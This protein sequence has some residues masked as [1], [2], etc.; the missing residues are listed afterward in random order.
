MLLKKILTEQTGRAKLWAASI[1]AALGISLLLFS[2]QIYFDF[3]KIL[4]GGHSTHDKNFVSVNKPVSLVNALVQSGFRAEEIEELRKQP[5]IESVATFTNAQ[6]KVSASSEMLHFYTEMFL[7]S[8]ENEFLD[9]EISKFNWV[10]GAQIVPIVL[11]RDYLALYNFGFAAS[12]GLPQ[13]SE[14]TIGN[15]PFDL[16]IRSDDGRSQAFRGRVMGFSERINSILVPKNF[17]DWANQHFGKAVQKSKT[18]RLLLA[19]RQGQDET[20][21]N[22]AK[23]NELE[24]S[25]SKL[26]AFAPLVYSLLTAISL[27]AVVLIVLSIFIFLLNYQLIIEKSS[28]NIRL[29]LQT[30]YAPQQ[31]IGVLQKSMFQWLFLTFSM[32]FLL[33]S[34][35]RFAWV[36]QL[37]KQ[38]FEL[39]MLPNW[40]IFLMS[41]TLC[42]VLILINI[43]NIKKA[44]L[45][46]A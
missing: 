18:A 29:L 36:T 38:G 7:E 34:S 3:Q 42:L 22:F 44:V 11:P 30:G 24:I 14:E 37:Q 15:F 41:I 26:S 2:T 20:F 12:Q 16:T 23:T 39:T 45:K 19:I 35:L 27:L 32:S 46:Q 10:E 43:S 8:V 6:F 4:G 13:F 5:F 9:V 31:I 21:K 25:G 40:I 28:A 33:F 1:A 17:M